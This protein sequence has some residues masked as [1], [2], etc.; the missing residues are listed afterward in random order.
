MQDWNQRSPPDSFRA[1]SWAPH[2]AVPS[3][4]GR[5]FPG[6]ISLASAV[7]CCR[8]QLSR[9]HAGPQYRLGCKHQLACQPRQRA[10]LHGPRR[11]CPRAK[12]LSVTHPHGKRTFSWDGLQRSTPA[13]TQHLL[14]GVLPSCAERIQHRLLPTRT[15]R[16]QA[17]PSWQPGS[18][19]QRENSRA[20]PTVH[21]K[22]APF[23]SCQPATTRCSCISSRSQRGRQPKG[24]QPKGRQPKGRPLGFQCASRQPKGRPLDFQSAS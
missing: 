6:M 20:C 11:G 22:R 9:P 5:R 7:V 10:P 1:S 23:G 19:R 18:W 13:P 3:Q 21:R 12:P 14:G 17:P 15:L 2:R 16:L 24:R 4:P 8:E